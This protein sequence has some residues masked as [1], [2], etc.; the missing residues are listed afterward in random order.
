MAV[1]LPEDDAIGHEFEVPV[2]LPDALPGLPVPRKAAKQRPV[3]SMSCAS[4]SSES[5]SFLDSN[6]GSARSSN[7]SY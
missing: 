2:L 5:L 7:E 1:P 6:K 3:H 4:M